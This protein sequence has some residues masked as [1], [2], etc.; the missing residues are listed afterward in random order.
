MNLEVVESST[1]Q[2]DQTAA[3][4]RSFVRQVLGDTFCRWGARLGITW[5]IVLTFLGVW[6]PF[7]ANT[8]PFVMMT[9]SGD[10]SFPILR[11][12]AP[13]D[14]I[15]VVLFVVF[16][17][18]ACLR[19][20]SFLKRAMVF[21][22]TLVAVTVASV[23]F[24]SPPINVVFSEYR[25]L[26]AAGEVSLIL[27]APIPYSP[28]DRLRDLQKFDEHDR[29][30]APNRH[31][32][33]GTEELGADVA[34]RL[35]HASRIALA[36]GFISTGIALSIGLIV[37]GL[38]GFYSGVADIVGM[39][40][41]EIIEAIPTLFLLLILVAML[42]ER[43][44]YLMMVVIGLTSWS[45]Y[46]RFIRA[47]FLK[48]RKQDFVQ[49]AIACGLPVRSILFR[50][51]L[52]NG[53]APVLVSASFGIASAILVESTLSFLGLGLVEEPSW[54]QMLEQA[55]G[56]GGTFYWWIALFPG[57]AIF[58]TVFAYNLIGEAL[59][60]ALDPHLKKAASM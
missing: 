29:L 14:Y 21:L 59:R 55:R 12:L 33:L 15:L 46:A 32:W 16:V 1:E 48:L 49:A 58:L 26:E 9:K 13:E 20:V 22:A 41:V 56:V 50:H 2:A 45:G 43:N 11:Y 38:M 28:T 39:R 60:D 53:I 54:G 57:L 18:L 47:E 24:V 36:I 31:H 7:L 23:M 52:P 42:E 8:H 10:L 44:L 25:E 27:R 40:M 5:I 37:G 30:V 4:P 51:M 19:S 17:I 35:I 3:K 6:A 34:S